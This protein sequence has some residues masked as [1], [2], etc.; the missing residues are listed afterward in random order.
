MVSSGPHVEGKLRQQ[1]QKTD[2]RTVST[3]RKQ[4]QLN[5]SIL[6]LF[7]FNPVEDPRPWMGN[8]HVKCRVFSPTSL[9]QPNLEIPSYVCPEVHFHS[10]SKSS[11]VANQD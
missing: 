3:V 7:L 9:N 10:D 1:E 5:I 2:G 8:T 6:N 11:Q 4:R